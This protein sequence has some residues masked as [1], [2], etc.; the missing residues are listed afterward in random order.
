[1]LEFLASGPKHH[2]EKQAGTA[3]VLCYVNLVLWEGISSSYIKDPRL[4]LLSSQRYVNFLLS[5]N[6]MS[7]HILEWDIVC[8]IKTTEFTIFQHL[9]TFE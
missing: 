3:T 5:V 9:V 6:K 8:K 1:M 4:V 2:V 7:L